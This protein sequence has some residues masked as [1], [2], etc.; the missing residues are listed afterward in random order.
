[1]HFEIDAEVLSKKVNYVY[2]LIAYLKK[3]VS[4]DT[5]FKR[6]SFAST[7]CV[8]GLDSQCFHQAP[9]RFPAWEDEFHGVMVIWTLNPAIRVQISVEPCILFRYV[10]HR[11]YNSL[12]FYNFPSHYD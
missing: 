2:K 6:I 12:R 10:N 7:P 5:Q 9:V 3:I 4:P 1:M 8:R 11:C